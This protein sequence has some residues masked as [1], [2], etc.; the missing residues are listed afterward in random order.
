MGGMIWICEATVVLPFRRV[1][2]KETGS[3]LAT[4]YVLRYDL[5]MRSHSFTTIL[6]GDSEGTGS[7]LASMDELDL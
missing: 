7:R 3:R 1:I 5:D 6:E 2:P 4:T